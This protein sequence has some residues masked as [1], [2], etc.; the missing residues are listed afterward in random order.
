[1]KIERVKRKKENL[2]IF[3]SGFMMNKELFDFLKMN[4]YDLFFIDDY[5]DFTIDESFSED[6]ESYFKVYLISFSLGVIAAADLLKGY[7]RYFNEAIAI[8]GTLKP[9]DDFFGIP[10]NIFNGTLEN[11]SDENLDRF[12]KRV[13]E[14]NYDLV[15]KYLSYDIE[16]AK[17]ELISIKNLVDSGIL[18]ENIYTKAIIS[19]DDRI[20]PPSNQISF[21]QREVKQIFVSGGHFPFYQFESWDDIIDADV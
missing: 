9:I 16:K 7:K 2:I 18:V 8:N 19:E 17:A 1:M 20:F 11:L 3:F 12:Y 4:N 10:V 15:N 13:F 6:I 5:R 14:K 21:W